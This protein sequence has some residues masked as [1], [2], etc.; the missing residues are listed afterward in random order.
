MNQP[1][2]ICLIMSDQHAWQVQHYAGDSIVRT[3]N[4]DRIASSGTV[5]MNAYTSDPV[6]VPAR[7]SMLSGQFASRC[8]VMSNKSALDSNRATFVHCLA[9]RGY[10]TTLCGRMHFVGPDQRHGFGKRIAGDITQVFH[11]RPASM[12]AERGV[13][14][15]TPQGGPSSLHIIGGGNSP[16]LEFD[17]YVVEHA[18]EYLQGSYEEPQFLCVGTYGPHHPY[19]APV[20]L[21]KY[22]YDKVDIPGETFNYPPHPAVLSTV[23]EDRDPNVVRAVRA[24]YYGMVEFEDEQIGK[25]YDAFQEYLGRNHREGIFVYVSDHG[26]HAGYRGYYGKSTF[27]EPSVHIPMIFSGDGVESGRMLYGAVSLMDIGPTLCEATGAV[28]PPEIDGVSL[29][30]QLSGGED[31]EERMVISEVNSGFSTSSRIIYG[32]MCKWR[33]FKLIHYLNYNQEDVLY[34]IE[35]DPLESMNVITEHPI[36]VEKMRK[37]M[38]ELCDVSINEIE[39]NARK[40]KANLNILTKCDFDSKEERWHAPESVRH[41]PYCMVSSKLTVEVWKQQLKERSQQE[42]K[43]NEDL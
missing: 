13:H 36:L 31:D 25:V 26:D 5:M 12:A 21:F 9:A 33:N 2:D 35:A 43:R 24:A 27:Y 6:C 7:M 3:P 40:E 22:Y 23:L 39:V 10:E 38:D 4:L 19:V 32:K 34:D 11:N 29:F 20:E 16:T 17:R 41:Y 28:Y 37:A 42:E 1:K 14:D 8:G 18:L 30:S 15:K